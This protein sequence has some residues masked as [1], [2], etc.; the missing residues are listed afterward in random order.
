MPTVKHDSHPSRLWRLGVI[1]GTIGLTFA[2]SVSS[3][4]AAT[5]NNGTVKVHD[6]T[7]GTETPRNEPHVCEF[8]LAFFFSDPAESGAWEIRSWSPTG[9]GSV[10]ES[11]TYLT[12]ADGFD[13]TDDMTLDDG[14]YRV[15]WQGINDTSWKHK[16]FWV[17]CPAGGGGA[18]GGG[19]GGGGQGE[20]G[21]QA[22]QG[23]PGQSVLPDAAMPPPEPSGLWVAAVAAAVLLMTMAGAV[24]HRLREQYI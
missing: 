1:L 20:T 19:N 15:N 22:G 8:Y 10:V 2:L 13:R 24:V 3:A 16:M 5:G 23:G 9:S 18:G 17:D 21:V 11:G 6:S 14:H 4:F 7:T 12:D